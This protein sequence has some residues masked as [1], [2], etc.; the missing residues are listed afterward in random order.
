MATRRFGEQQECVC[1]C[2]GGGGREGKGVG[3]Q[4]PHSKRVT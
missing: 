1:V 3:V 4:K 2:G